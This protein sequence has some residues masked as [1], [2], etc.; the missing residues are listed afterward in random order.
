MIMIYDSTVCLDLQHYYIAEAY[1]AIRHYIA[2][3]SYAPP[4]G[5]EHFH[6]F[7]VLSSLPP[8]GVLMTRA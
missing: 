8:S 6:K 5:R 1:H 7:A 3:D 4:R 2:R